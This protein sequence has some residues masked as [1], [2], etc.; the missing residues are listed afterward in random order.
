MKGNIIE[1]NIQCWNVSCTLT[2]ILD[3]KDIEFNSSIMSVKNV[4]NKS[5]ADEEE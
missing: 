5:L 2:I 3:Y 1:I 4:N